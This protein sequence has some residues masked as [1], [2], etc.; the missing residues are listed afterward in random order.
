VPRQQF[1]DAVNGVRRYPLEDVAEIS[2]GFDVIVAG[3]IRERMEKVDT[4][5]VDKTGTL[6]GGK[7][8]VVVI[9]PAP[10]V[11]PSPRRCH[12]PPASSGMTSGRRPR[13]LRPYRWLIKSF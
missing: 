11:Y 10:G 2:F 13:G 1:G 12:S 3:R 7:P 8:R 6:T 4:L 5:V 9:V